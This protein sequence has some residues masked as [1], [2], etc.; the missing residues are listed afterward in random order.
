[1]QEILHK[2]TYRE[3]NWEVRDRKMNLE[4]YSAL[5]ELC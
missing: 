1:M 2:A 5:L 4:I 3:Q